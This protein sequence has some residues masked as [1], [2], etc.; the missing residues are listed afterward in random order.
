MRAY[1]LHSTALYS[2]EGI[3]AI[4]QNRQYKESN[5]RRIVTARHSHTF[6]RV[7]IHKLRII[8]FNF[9]LVALLGRSPDIVGLILVKSK[10]GTENTDTSTVPRLTFIID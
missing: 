9:Y 8:T 4:P 7:R 5:F 2:R 3:S 6:S 1:T 10:Y